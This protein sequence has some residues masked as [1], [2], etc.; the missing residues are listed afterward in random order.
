[1]GFL[2]FCRGGQT[3]GFTVFLY[4]NYACRTFAFI[5]YFSFKL[6]RRKNYRNY[7]TLARTK[8]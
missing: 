1:M 6:T 8:I 3:R 5:Y 2:G 7:K 4:L